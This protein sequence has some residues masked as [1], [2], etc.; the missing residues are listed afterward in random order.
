MRGKPTSAPA[1]FYPALT[2]FHY[3]CEGPQWPI[4]APLSE[5]AFNELREIVRDGIAVM[6][7]GCDVLAEIYQGKPVPPD[8][9]K[10]WHDAFDRAQQCGPLLDG[11]F[12]HADHMRA[13]GAHAS[14]YVALQAAEVTT[15]ARC[16]DPAG[17]AA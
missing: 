8:I 6:Y 5:P 7:Q 14:S 17:L 4:T 11:T 12:T 1:Y 9:Q 3:S 15:E 13:W 16:D 2:H 10:V